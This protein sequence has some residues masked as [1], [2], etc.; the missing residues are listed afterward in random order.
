[1]PFDV[2]GARKAGY[3][4]SEIADFLA[5]SAKFDLAS[6]RK[7]GYDDSEIVGFLAKAPKAEEGGLINAMT[8][9]ND[10]ARTE[11]DAKAPSA[12]YIGKAAYKGLQDTFGAGLGIAAGIYNNLFGLS[13][14]ELAV[15]SGPK[16]DGSFTKEDAERIKQTSPG[17]LLEG[18]SRDRFASGE[19]AME[20]LSEGAKKYGQKEYLTLDPEKSALLSPTRVIGDVLGS[21]PSTLVLA[22]TARF[23]GTAATTARAEALAA[24]ATEAAANKA[25]I[26]AATKAVTRAGAAGEGSLGYEQ[27]Y[28]ST[29]KKVLD[30]PLDKLVVSPEYKKLTEE[31]YDAETA[32]Q[33]LAGR[34]GNMAG[35]IAGIV[36]AG[37]NLASGRVLGKV[38]GEGGDLLARTGKAASTEALQEGVQS[39]GEQL[40]ENVSVR[41]TADPSQS[42]SEGVAESALQGA[43]VGGLT[44]GAVGAAAGQNGLINEGPKV[45]DFAQ[46]DQVNR[47][48]E[49]R[50]NELAGVGALPPGSPQAA[51]QPPSSVVP[52]PAATVEAAPP[53]ATVTPEQKISVDKVL[54]APDVETAIAAAAETAVASPTGTPRASLDQMID[55]ARQSLDENL[56]N[57]QL[58]KIEKLFGGLN[59]GTVQKADDGIL[60]YR[61]AGGAT[62]PLQVWAPDPKNPDAGGISP[63][64]AKAQVAH[65]KD[66]G[67]DVVYIRDDKNIPFDGVVDPSQPNTIFLSSNPT[68]NAAQVGQH[69]VTHVF[70]GTTLPDG[71]SLADLMQQ[72]IAE[73]ITNEGIEHAYEMFGS[74]APDRASFPNTPEGQAAHADAVLVHLFNELGADI[75]G[76]APKFE[77]FIQRVMDAVETRYGGNVAADVF[78]KFMNGIREAIS[79][80][81]TFFSGETQSQKWVTNLEK[82]HGT[83][84]QMYAAKYGE[85]AK[86]PDSAPAITPEQVVKLAEETTPPPTRAGPKPREGYE[87]AKQQAQTYKRWLGELDEQRRTAA[88]KS[89][90]VA[91]L[92][93]EEKEIVGKVR[94]GEKYLTKSARNRLEKVRAEIEE[95]INPKGDSADMVVV[96][97]K[98]VEAQQ[99]MADAA[100]VSK[101]KKAEAPAPKPASGEPVRIGKPAPRPA[102]TGNPS[103][104][105]RFVAN[106][107]AQDTG[108]KPQFSPKQTESEAF[109][110]W[111]GDSKVVDKDGEPLVVYHGTGSDIEAFQ[112][113]YVGKTS[114]L[115]MS[116]DTQRHGFYFTEDKNFAS[117]FADQPRFKRTGN[118]VIPVY[119]S[120]EN[121]L[122]MT[123]D[124]V[125]VE[126]VDRLVDQ[127]VDRKWLE[128]YAGNAADTW[129]QFDDENGEF[130]VDAIKAA[131]FDGVRMQELDDDN[132][133]KDVWIVFD[134]TQIKSA[135]GNNGK[136]DPKDPRIQFSPKVE[137]TPGP[138]FF[139]ALERAVDTVK[140]DKAPPGQW[141]ATIRNMPGIKAEE[142]KTTG[143]DKWL[144]A[145][146]RPVTKT[147]VLEQIEL[148]SVQ[149]EEV[150]KG[151]VIGPKE[152]AE[153][154]EL[155]QQ[156]R[157]E[158]EDMPQ[159][160]YD[161]M[162][163]LERMANKTE[164]LTKF[165]QY[166]L[167]GGENYRELLLTLPDTKQQQWRIEKN[168]DGEYDVIDHTG[169]VRYTGGERS[170][171]AEYLA[172]EKQLA[173]KR[174]GRSFK[175]GHWD[176]PNVLAHAR[177]DERTGPNGEKIMHV[178]EIQSDWHQKGRREGYK[179]PPEELKAM[180]ARVHALNDEFDDAQQDY[181]REYNALGRLGRESMGAA[182]DAVAY[183]AQADKLR[184]AKA[185]YEEAKAVYEEAQNAYVKAAAG[186][187]DAPFKST[188]H[189]L[190]FKRL[191]RYAVDNGFDTIT[192]DTGETNADR[193]DLSQ[194]VSEVLW[195]KRR[196]VE[197]YDITVKDID[198]D[199][200]LT[201]DAQTPAQIAEMIGK[202]P[203]DRIINGE[204]LTDKWNTGPHE[205]TGSLTDEKLK[206]GGEGMKGFYDKI[207]PAFVDKYTKKWGGKVD[208]S[209]VPAPEN[210]L[211]DRYSVE[212]NRSGEYEIRDTRSDEVVQTFGTPGLANRK[213]R[214]LNGSE[215]KER[216]AQVHS[217]KITPEMRRA[218][219][220]GQPKFSPKAKPTA[221]ELAKEVPGLKKVVSNLAP[222]EIQTV[223][224]RTAD[225]LVKLFT[226]LPSS[227]ETAAV[228]FSGRAKRGWYKHSAQ[229]IVDVFGQ[230]DGARFA[231]LLAALSPQTSVESN[232]ENALRTWV[233][234]EKAG[235][236][237]DPKTIGKIMGQSVQGT[238]GE[239]SVLDA[240]RGNTIR[241]LTDA[242]PGRPDF[243]L[244]GPKVNS[245]A[246]N[247]RNEVNEVTNDAWMATFAAI[248]PEMLAAR[249]LENKVGNV[250]KSFGFKSP[251]YVAMSAM[252][253]DAAK[254]LSRRTGQTWTPAEVQETVWSWAKTLYERRDRAGEYRTAQQILKAA[255]MTH[256]DVTSTPDFAVLL[257]RG[258][259]R[260]I[261]EGEKYG[262]ALNALERARGGDAD[263]RRPSGPSVS[264]TG[265][266]G[267]GFAQAAFERHLQR[268]AARLER[269]RTDRLTAKGVNP[270]ELI[271][272]ARDSEIAANMS[273]ATG[274][275]PGIAQLADAANA[276][277]ES[278]ARLVNLIA[279]ETLERLVSLVPGAELEVSRNG[280]LYGGALEPS[281]GVKITFPETSRGGVLAALAKFAGN[282]NQEQV[283]VRQATIDPAGR[284]YTDGS[285]ATPVYTFELEEPLSRAEIEQVIADSGLYGLN[286]NDRKL[287]AYYVGDPRDE[288]AR[289]E[290]SAAIE[291]ARDSLGDRARSV[292][293]STAR[294]WAY[295]IGEGATAGYD[296]IAGDLPRGTSEYTEIPR[297]IAERELGY[298]VE[299][300][301][302]AEQIT[303]AQR[304][305]QT[306]IADHYDAL[307]DNDM[308]NPDVRRA[309]QELS[310]EIQKQF[311]AL[312]VKV[313]VWDK[314]GEPYKTSAELRRDV[315]DNNHMWI[316]AT[317]PETFGPPGADFS[318]H[319]LLEFTG[320]RSNNGQPLLVND[321]L[322]AVHDYYAHMMAPV[323]FGP[324]GEEAAWKNHLATIDNPWAR[325][326]LTSETRGQNSW[327]NFGAHVDPESRLA[328]RPFARQKAAL[329]PVE[330]MLTGNDAVDGPTYEFIRTL[331]DFAKNG[332]LPRE[333]NDPFADFSPRVPSALREK[334]IRKDPAYKAMFAQPKMQVAIA[335][336]AVA[337]KAPESAAPSGGVADEEE[338]PP[339]RRALQPIEGT[340][341]ERARAIN[342]EIY[343]VG[344]EAP[345]LA[346]ALALVNEDP[347]RAIAIAM[348]EKNP[349]VGVHPEFVFMA[350]EQMAVDTDN[351]ALQERLSRSRIAEEATT[352]GQRIA[353]WRNRMELSPVED[354]RR[355]RLAR[356]ARAK[357]KGVD[358]GV[359][360]D[361][362][363]ER[364]IAASRKA[365]KS[366]K[367]PNW[368]DFI[369][370]IVCKT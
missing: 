104:E 181:R 255:D 304:A 75:G 188:W 305:L 251:G 196:G 364:G 58:A 225:K 61:T 335:P 327:V 172:E 258:I 200:V 261:L 359:E 22:L 309:Y 102:E 300:S 177:F 302:Q 19:K 83:L 202:D 344:E 155:R 187:P 100:S 138:V 137:E 256:E 1:M 139:S 307:P 29:R 170:D 301:K 205:A 15:L 368:N 67:I 352:Q 133:V 158:M 324:K 285:Y 42:L 246:K 185:A 79:T 265:A 241:A 6:A 220:Q 87:T 226:S 140:F 360:T 274:T 319:P 363:V 101:E 182:Y 69:E 111:F 52:P 114:V 88:R 221:K 303:D 190:T 117:A 39:A 228:A 192:W 96:R 230:Q 369:M 350:V 357:S 294:L 268:A 148:G 329:L 49:H 18:A 361:K 224:A 250:G 240:W 12:E 296:A 141:L 260:K 280:G 298:D 264:V 169:R 180:L 77:G 273:A 272:D 72:Q 36:D 289:A 249:R 59:T 110:K 211:S 9:E 37:T 206:V 295:G 186:V 336:A 222:D 40:G 287:E 179:P 313:D 297:A 267:S 242:D 135:I 115:G 71:T 50:D 253:R 235:R 153:Y 160:A 308:G 38:I 355:I 73:G 331:P 207:L 161:R 312:P 320:R 349:P 212:Q 26:D 163:E 365:A 127:G 10:A 263:A 247:L 252:V 4:D 217:L 214:R 131:G 151:A 136:F 108:G 159:V 89:P 176:E 167:P 292:G 366:T 57:R 290:F 210:T 149:I 332:S 109:K 23:G 171:A 31:G 194:Q 54:A 154:D 13:D 107:M 281:L 236:P 248:E 233:N 157:A 168:E 321:E 112:K 237:T 259:Y 65:Y 60:E 134:P 178:A 283:H 68:R 340:G 262:E 323:G 370:S 166:K 201:K 156:Y 314:P 143:I 334:L 209:A 55:E 95:R 84:A 257:T 124:G 245:F 191:L 122:V 121:P 53:P 92:R 306:K 213:A 48:I 277:D 90:E 70:E 291:R 275:I 367:K 120:V 276:G 199:A 254:V 145:Q 44:G 35:F 231:A 97:A 162:V 293:R 362:V 193:Y 86:L 119:L 165:E 269:I 288:A 147:E 345:Q 62:F 216:T 347:D 78:Q 215:A 2:A 234:W 132:E 316:F 7:S 152:E 76:E 238:G 99:R 118:N 173:P 239:A 8:R 32:R 20:G 338:K 146:T 17:N 126:D 144:G 85:V 317:T 51:A 81:R 325:W 219:L 299:V 21:L 328:D 218:V 125:N 351:F 46:P 279:H 82:V 195:A 197:E 123:E 208:N 346:R 278:A 63:E 16:D 318:G 113:G 286:F 266:E 56:P 322:R 174:E 150:E 339:R 354:M 28:E 175:S 25:A 227:E 129:E 130:F 27:Q 91:R 106:Q 204:G 229:A 341:R 11:A 270:R 64:L 223:S 271:A 142:I 105:D 311:A 184:A 189:E 333:I 66:L 164:S 342:G 14:D 43:V 183:G 103:D 330:H 232:L 24:G 343:T 74:T 47:Y 94:G 198:G 41:E 116:V 356:E 243:I 45:E 3:S 34:A 348:R 282:F 310:K 337:P 93:A 326:A 30:M 5:P 358:A 80:L 203:T 98:M 33:L 244:S 128:Q 284:V 315:L 353:A